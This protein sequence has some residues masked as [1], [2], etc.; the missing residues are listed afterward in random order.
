MAGDRFAAVII[1]SGHH[2]LVL[3]S[4]STRAGLNTLIVERRL[5]AGGGLGAE[6]AASPSFLHHLPSLLPSYRRAARKWA[7]SRRSGLRS[8]ARGGVL[9]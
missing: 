2:V 9:R 4:G 6:A 1:G 8:A 3:G 7:P 5:A